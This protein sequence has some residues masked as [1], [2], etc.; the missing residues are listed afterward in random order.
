MSYLLSICIPSITERIHTTAILIGKIQKQIDDNKLNKYIQLVIHMDNRSVPLIYKRNI[1]QNKSKGKYFVHLDDDDDIS[2]D[3][4]ITLYN[5]IN[6][7]SED[8]DV[9]TYNQL[10]LLENDKFYVM[11]DLKSSMNLDYVGIHPKD[12]L[13]VFKR[14]PWQWCAWNQRF[15][16]VFRSDIDTLGCED[17]NWLRRVKL[18]Y[19]KT[20]KNIPKTLHTYNFQDPTKSSTQSCGSNI[21][22]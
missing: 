1:L 13:R 20:Q 15:N 17:P 21:S 2:D 19:P 5:T 22:K 18:E 3:Y 14:F 8:V 16:I 7:L 12:N 10:A 6:E 9:I 4:V 11:C